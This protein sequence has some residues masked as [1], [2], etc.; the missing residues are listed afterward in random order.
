VVNKFRT[1]LVT[2]AKGFIGKNLLEALSRQK[3]IKVYGFDVDEDIS[4]FKSALRKA[5]IICHLTGVNRPEKEEEFAIGNTDSVKDII[6]LLEEMQQTPAIIF[7]SSTQAA[8]NNPYGKSKKAA[9]DLLYEYGKKTSAAVYIYRLTNV[10]GK[11]C[12][13][14][15]NSVVATFCHNIANHLDINISDRA[16]EIELIY[17]DDVID[18]ILSV[19]KNCSEATP[20]QY[21]SV[22][23]SWKIN[24]GDLADRIYQLREMRQSLN[25]PDMADNF[26]KCLYATFLSYLDKKDF[27]YNLEK[28]IDER[29]TLA[30]LI[31][32]SHLGQIFVSKTYG[33]A[34][35]GN[36][37]HNTKAEK[38][39]VIQGEAIIR[40]R[41]IL[42]SEITT[43]H[44]S[45][46]DM[47]IVDIPP[48]YT[49]S[50][51]NLSDGE[52]IVLF[53]ADE[54]FDPD[55]PDTYHEEV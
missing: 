53:W 26:T 20:R 32:S 25:I 23:P 10:F 51:E 40:F 29:G 8:M 6:S 54:I 11:W 41:H 30:E 27:S 16:R 3:N 19:I 46:D 17:I 9:E 4:V 38:F 24:L 18:S 44:V 45:G 47:K 49:H 31:K 43:Y 14:N 33:K 50:I 42:S 22:S 34:V 15:Y 5:D 35:R 48:G 12:R 37:Y 1:V 36:H 39:C 2:G 13:P 7:T 52:M 28:R 21:L 55:K